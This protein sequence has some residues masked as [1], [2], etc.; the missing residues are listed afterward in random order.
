MSVAPTRVHVSDRAENPSAN[1]VL[2]FAEELSG[3]NNENSAPS[4][5]LLQLVALIRKAE[6]GNKEDDAWA[7]LVRNELRHMKAAV[8]LINESPIIAL[9]FGNNLNA[10]MKLTGILKARASEKEMESQIDTIVDEEL[11]PNMSSKT[12]EPSSVFFGRSQKSRQRAQKDRD[13]EE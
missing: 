6:A 13:A 1:D 4:L 7:P 3:E 8:R 2:K 5:G 10:A 11:V 12:I 9:K